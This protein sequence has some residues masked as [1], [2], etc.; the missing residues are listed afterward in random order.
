MNGYAKNNEDNSWRWV[1]IGSNRGI[2]TRK[3]NIDAVVQRGAESNKDNT[4][5]SVDVPVRRES[6]SNEEGAIKEG[7]AEM[8]TNF[9]V[10]TISHKQGMG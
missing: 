2:H 7:T 8:H 3:M 10:N 9:A 1:V 6:H 5:P 4:R